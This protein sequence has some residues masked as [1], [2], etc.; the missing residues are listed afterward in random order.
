MSADY[1]NYQHSGSD[2]SSR[3]S[4]TVSDQALK[5]DAGYDF[6]APIHSGYQQQSVYDDSAFPERR[7]Y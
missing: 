1:G 5:A 2:R 4:S 7:L 3:C 6:N